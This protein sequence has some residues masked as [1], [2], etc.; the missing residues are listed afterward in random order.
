MNAAKVLLMA[1]SLLL[2]VVGTAAADWS[3]GEHGGRQSAERE[4][5]VGGWQVAYGNRLTQGDV[6]RGEVQPGVSIFAARATREMGLLHEWA[7][8]L[9]QQAANLAAVRD[10]GQE[11]QFQAMRFTV[12]TVRELIRGRQPGSQ[13]MELN[14]VTIKAGLLE[15]RDRHERGAEVIFVPYVG[16]KAKLG[17]SVPW[18]NGPVQEPANPYSPP[19][20]QSPHQHGGPDWRGPSS[21]EIMNAFSLKNISRNIGGGSW[22][23]VAYIDGPTDFLRRISSV[24]YHLHPSFKPSVQYGDSSKPGHPLSATGW[25]VFNLKA[26]VALDDGTRRTYEHILQFR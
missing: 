24:T 22:Q 13:Q 1:A 7:N 8:A 25:G 14:S 21:A 23:W 17:G 3:A 20:I 18:S 15:Y 5:E 19:V 12:R 26:E 16:M 11:D 6:E 2:L 9:V 4:V 10:V